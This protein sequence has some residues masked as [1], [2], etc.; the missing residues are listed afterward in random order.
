MKQYLKVT[1]PIWVYVTV[2]CFEQG[3]LDEINSYSISPT[4]GA[5]M[6]SS[7]YVNDDGIAKAI[8]KDLDKLFP[9]LN[10]TE[11]DLYSDVSEDFDSKISISLNCTIGKDGEYH[12]LEE[13]QYKLW[14]SGDIAVHIVDITM[15]FM[16]L[17]R[18]DS[19][20]AIKIK[21]F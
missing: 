12:R 19:D 8:A 9:L 13:E 5:S 11:D 1:D 2:D 14:E 7:L 10:I 4:A 21:G 20:E 16:L 18:A 6:Y 17:N 15:D 3:A